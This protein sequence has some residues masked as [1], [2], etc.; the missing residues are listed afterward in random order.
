MSEDTRSN[1]SAGQQ[2]VLWLVSSYV[3]AVSAVLLACFLSIPI[4]WL[5]AVLNLSEGVFL[6]LSVTPIVASVYLIQ[7]RRVGERVVNALLAS[8]FK[9]TLDI[10]QVQRVRT[11]HQTWRAIQRLK[12]EEMADWTELYR[13]VQHVRKEVSNFN[14]A[15]VEHEKV[16]RQLQNWAMA[17]GLVPASVSEVSQVVQRQIELGSQINNLVGRISDY[18]HRIRLEGIGLLV[19]EA[20]EREARE[21]EWTKHKSQ[22]E[23]AEKLLAP[24][25]WA[26]VESIWRHRWLSAYERSYRQKREDVRAWLTMPFDPS[27]ALQRQNA[28]LQPLA[29]Q[30]ISCWDGKVDLRLIKVKEKGT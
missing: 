20:A 13:M 3:S 10:G 22:L 5:A 17:T 4:A 25:F 16:V 23:Y 6:I 12:K 8:V 24:T 2:V 19:E 9:L 7:R 30:T 28:S 18:D 27:P 11:V 14:R 15:I 26:W 21:I 1:A 29:G